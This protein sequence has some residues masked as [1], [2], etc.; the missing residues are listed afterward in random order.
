LATSHG[1]GTV[2]AIG[3]VVKSVV[4]RRVIAQNLIVNNAADFCS[5]AIQHISE[6]KISVILVDAA[7]M[8]ESRN[9][10]Q[11]RLQHVPAIPKIQKMHHFEVASSSE[12]IC[13]R[14]SKREEKFKKID[15]FSFDSNQ[16]PAKRGRGR[17]KKE[18]AQQKLSG[19]KKQRGLP[20]KKT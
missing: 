13:W 9:M 2:D 8:T 3:G 11:K 14:T 17:P 18:V 1:K 6:E 12:L 5:L 15:N 4:N 10:L 16:V 7:K 19:M 20:L